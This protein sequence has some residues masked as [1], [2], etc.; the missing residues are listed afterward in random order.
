MTT[1]YTV[2]ELLTTT[3]PEAV[4]AQLFALMSASG[5]SVTAWQPLSPMWAVVDACSRLLAASQGL[6]TTVN[7]GGYRDTADGNWLAT[8]SRQTYGVDKILA[9]YATGAL[10]LTNGG[11]GVYD[12]DP[13]DLIVKN[14]TT[15]KT[16]TNTDAIHIGALATVTDTPIR[17][18]EI[19]ADS[20]AAI[21]EVDDLVTTLLGVTCSNAAAVVGEDA[22]TSDALRERDTDSLGA[23]SPD[24]PK[25]AY[26]YVAKTPTLNGGVTVNRAR[27][28]TPP[29][30]G[31]VTVVIAGPA[32]AL[33]SPDVALVQA[34]IDDN[35]EPATVAATV[36]SATA[37]A[38]TIDTDVY[39][40]STS[41]FVDADVQVFVKQALLDYVNGS[42]DVEDEDG[43][44]VKAGVKPLP[45]GGIDT[46]SGGKVSWRALVGA[47]ER[48]G[49]DDNT[50][51]ISEATLDV[52]SDVALTEAEVATLVIGDIDVT[53][54]FI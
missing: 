30:D 25:E 1:V 12:L 29:G 8:T 21:G 5:V 19:G 36:I 16:Y 54:H 31:T 27:T 42:A 50:R 24:G 41:G 28:L 37:V 10:T 53:V 4:K 52:E 45:I 15:G 33:S 22:E 13:G 44:V 49:P 43:N 46:G 34:G 51:P 23:L 32:G 7:R 17:A 35:A 6:Q 20:N 9:T 11:G 38:L 47:I 2:D 40:P 3:T 48:S 39:L 18:T 14:T 26:N